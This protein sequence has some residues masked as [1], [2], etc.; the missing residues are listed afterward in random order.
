MTDAPI[1]HRGDHDCSECG[2]SKKGHRHSN[3][4]AWIVEA[5]AESGLVHDLVH[6]GQ[7]LLSLLWAEE[8]LDIVSKATWR[9]EHC[10]AIRMKI[11]SNLT[12]LTTK[13]TLHFVQD[14][15]EAVGRY[16]SLHPAQRNGSE[17]RKT[18]TN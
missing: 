6:G 10:L 11:Y 1:S 16:H 15:R 13:D 9:M 2:D 4:E 7:H 3:H 17:W 5:Q 18:L 12:R 14:R 8:A